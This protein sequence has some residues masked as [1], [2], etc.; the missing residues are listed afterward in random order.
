MGIGYN[1]MPN[2]CDDDMLPWGKSTSWLDSKYPYVCHAEMNAIMNRNSSSVRGCTL[3]VALFPCNDCAKLIIQSGI[4]RVL[5][6]SDK[7][8]DKDSMIASRRLLDLAKIEYQQYIPKQ[9]K[10]VIDFSVIN[11]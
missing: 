9:E 8:K 4:T 3:Y 11:P 5:Y 1:G 2:H 10:V 6:Y 7:H